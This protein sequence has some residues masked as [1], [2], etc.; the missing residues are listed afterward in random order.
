M[1]PLKIALLSRWYWEESRHHH[2]DEEG[3]SS[4]QLAEAVAALGNEVVVLTQKPGIRKVKQ[5]SI[6][7]LETWASPRNRHRD[8]ITGIRD[9][10]AKTAYSY[11]QI[12]SDALALRDFLAQ[13]G[14][15]DVI[16]AHAESP[17]GVAAAMAAKMG[18]KLPPVLLQVQ[19]LR[20]RFVDSGPKFIDYMPLH[21]A[22]RH[23]ARILTSSEMVAESLAAYAG[24]GLTVEDLKAKTRVVYP[25]LQRAFFRAAMETASVTGPMPDRVLFLGTLEKSKGALVFLK[26]L[27]KTEASKRVATFTVVGDFNEFSRRNIRIWEQAQEETRLK[28]PGAKMEYLGRVSSY[29]VIRQIRL[30]RVIVIPSLFDPFPRGLLEALALGRPVVTT[31]KVGASQ[32]VREHGCGVVV[33][34]NDPDALARAIDVI[35]S[36]IVPFADKAAQIGPRLLHEFSSEAIA[37]QITRHLIKISG[38]ADEE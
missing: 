33:A 28:L 15:F 12:Y 21:F 31:D 1:R 13:R 29:E 11:S 7:S 19:A 2:D 35:L 9:R 17:D 26:A 30:A 22:F 5:V 25:N 18:V 10:M 3:G 34:P 20:Y 4:R 16:W 23:A 37:R 27:P 24:A 32:L 6:D 38:L 14:P 36:P 8:L